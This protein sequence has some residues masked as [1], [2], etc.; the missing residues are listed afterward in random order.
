MECT[1]CRAPGRPEALPEGLCRPCRTVH[2][3]STAEEPVDTRDLPDAPDIG[4][5]IAELRDLLKA[6]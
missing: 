2:T 3:S 4:T 6:P 5:Y 1:E